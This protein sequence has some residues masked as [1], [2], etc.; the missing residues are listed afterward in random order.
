MKIRTLENYE[1]Y[2]I[3]VIDDGPGFVPDRQQDDGMSHMGIKNVRERLHRVCGGDLFIFSKPGK[4]TD[5]M[6][7]VPKNNSTMFQ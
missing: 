7:L 1:Y 5:A 2:K 6:I 4:G 3:H